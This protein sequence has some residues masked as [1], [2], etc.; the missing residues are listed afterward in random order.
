M[1]T[2]VPFVDLKNQYFSLKEE[3]GA[4]VA[5][6]LESAQFV[7]GP[8]VA[9]FERE[10]AAYCRA[11]FG[12]GVNTG[13]SA[14]H[15][16]LRAAGIGPGDEVLTVPFTFVATVAAIRYTGATPI[17]V[18][19][20]PRSY[21]MDPSRIEAALTPRTK[22][23]L[24]V[25]LYGQM[26]DMDP[27]LDIARRRSLTVIEDACQ[28]HGAEYRGRRAGS[29]GDLGCFSFYPGKNLGA[30]GEGGMVVTS[31]PEFERKVRMMRDWGQEKKYFHVMEG[32][33]YRLEELQAAIL[34][35][36]LRRLERWTEDRR[37]AASEYRTRLAEMVEPPVEMDY[38]RHVFHLYAVRVSDR[39]A[40]QEKLKAEGV[41]T[42]IHYPIPVHLQEAHADLGYRRGAF[43]CAEQAADEVL[44]LPMFPEITTA[45]IDRV[46]TALRAATEMNIAVAG[47]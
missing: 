38:A 13:T 10:F 26:A 24:P 11:A 20:D 34:R 6:V 16:A 14:L 4:T 46:G 27:I 2:T 32:F 43:P 28:A 15:L 19:I 35:V 44:S 36:K 47:D 23:I 8:E 41:Q 12:V 30:Y 33:N 31:T 29:L 39:A 3:I 1:I 5:R 37:A 9:A 40:V 42:G 17:F 25:H 7:L 45:Q 18:D 22:A 21:T